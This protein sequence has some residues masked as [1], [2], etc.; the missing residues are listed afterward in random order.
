MIPKA[1]EASRRALTMP[2]VYEE[3]LPSPAEATLAL[4]P[5]RAR[6]G[7]V[8]LDVTDRPL[9]DASGVTTEEVS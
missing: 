8:H 4:S 2:G 1:S 9:T 5:L 6:I 3:R 7:S